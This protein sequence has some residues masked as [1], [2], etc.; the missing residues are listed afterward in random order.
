MFI[1][2]C[3]IENTNFWTNSVFTAPC[4]YVLSATVSIARQHFYM[5]SV[6]YYTTAHGNYL[7]TGLSIFHM[8]SWCC[9]Q[10]DATIMLGSLT[11]DSV[12]TFIS[13]L[14]DPGLKFTNISILKL[15]LKSSWLKSSWLKNS[16]V[17][18]AMF[19]KVMVEKFVVEK[20]QVEISCNHYHA[21]IFE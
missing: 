11:N 14:K 2:I 7:C 3:L 12:P 8:L 21:G 4:T 19:E 15:W 6:Y 9:W 16:L 13:G 10:K 18:K 1:T 17:G 5:H 20:F